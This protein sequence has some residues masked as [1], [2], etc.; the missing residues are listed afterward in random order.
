[1]LDLHARWRNSIGWSGSLPNFI[2][3]GTQKGGTTELYDQLSLHPQIAPSFAKEVH[4]FDANFNKGIEWYSAFFPRSPDAGRD[5]HIASITGEASPCYLFHPDVARRVE[6]D[7]ELGRR[8]GVSGT[9]WYLLDGV[10][11]GPLP[12][13]ARELRSQG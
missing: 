5:C 10:P 8:D 2:V 12:T 1:M 9:P 7:V 13:L 3:V 4:F 11:S 6:R